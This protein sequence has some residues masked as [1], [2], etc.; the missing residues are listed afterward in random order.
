MTKAHRRAR[1][2]AA[3]VAAA[4]IGSGVTAVAVPTAA[5]AAATAA[6]WGTPAQLTG[7]A[8]AVSLV[9]VTVAADGSA[10]G[11]WSRSPVGGSAYELLVARRA[12]GSSSWGAAHTLADISTESGYGTLLASADGTVTAAWVENGSEDRLL[13][14]VLA[15]DGSSWSDPAE[16]TSAST[17]A[18]VH[19][20]EDAAGGVTAVW[21]NGSTKSAVESAD[22]AEPG[23]A[24]TTPVQLASAT[25]TGEYLGEPQLAVA[26]DGTATVAYGVETEAGSTVHTVTRAASATAWGDPVLVSDAGTSSNSPRIAAGA[27]GAV[28]AVW[29]ARDLSTEDATL[30]SATRPAGSDT[31]G[32]IEPVSATADLSE[33]PVPLTGPGGDVTLVWVDYTGSFGTRTA[34]R[35]AATGTWSAVRTLSTHYVPEQFDAAIAADGTV[36]AVWTQ[37]VSDADEA[38]RVLVSATRAVDGTWSGLTTVS[39]ASAESVYGQVAI[40]PDGRATAVLDTTVDGDGIDTNWQLS[41]ATTLPVATGPTL[42][43]TARTASTLTCKVTWSGAT[44]PTSYAWL[45]DGKAISGA[46]AAKRKLTGTDYN[47]KIACR[48]SAAN[49]GGTATATSAAKTVAVGPELTATTKPSIKGTAKVGN[50]LTAKPGTWSPAA[51]SYGYVWKRAGK[52]ISGA[53]KSTYKLVKADKGKKITVTVTAKRTGYAGGKATSKSVTPKG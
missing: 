29:V 38:E 28:T 40:A 18:F 44:S 37:N 1:I 43:G 52:A 4:V 11:M 51:T 50:K 53:T 6:A 3:L 19:L 42:S 48:A 7:T 2:S 41:A 25:G 9:D 17:L 10:V 26:A 12:A 36:R 39:A 23:A 13:A 20:G 15:K 24:W 27:D 31:W 8:D 47:H 5:A 22:R 45:R 21:M 49:E 33:T 46:T 16:V 30:V 32:A 14:A 35:S 34:T